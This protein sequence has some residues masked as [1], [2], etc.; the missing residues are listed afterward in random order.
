MVSV[1]TLI[2]MII[3]I[4]IWL[5]IAN[6]ILSWLV[7][8]NVVNTRN[9]FVATVGT[10]LYKITEPLLRPLRNIIPN[11]GGIDISPIVLILLLIFVQNL[12]WEYL[13]R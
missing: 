6:A 11:F 9:Q 1:V 3:Q 10:F 8:F 2:S 12:M 4:F 5:L 7:A 13:V